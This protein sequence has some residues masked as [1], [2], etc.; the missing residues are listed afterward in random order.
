MAINRV[1]VLKVL[2]R[3]SQR[4]REV[5]ELRCEGLIYKEIGNQLHIAEPTVKSTMSHIYIKL[6]L[7]GL[8]TTQRHQAL[9]EIICPVLKRDD[10]P[11]AAEEP[12]IIE[13]VPSEVEEMVTEDEY[14]LVPVKPIS[15]EYH[16]PQSSNLKRRPSI[17]GNLGWLITGIALTAVVLSILGDGGE[18]EA[19]VT[20]Q[21]IEHT[22]I[23]ER[24]ATVLV[25]L[26]PLPVKSTELTEEAGSIVVTS[27][28][29]PTDTPISISFNPPGYIFIDDFERGP[30]P[31]WEIKYGQLGMA[32][33]KYTVTESFQGYDKIE[34][35]AVLNENYWNNFRLTLNLAPFERGYNGCCYAALGLILR[36]SGDGHSI[37][38][39]IHPDDVGIEFGILNPTGKWEPYAGSFVEGRDLDF[40]LSTREH[41]IV[42]EAIGETYLVFI[43][44]IQITSATIPETN[45]GAIGLWFVPDSTADEVESYAPRIES[46]TIEALP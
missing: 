34:H 11:P 30:D 37:G 35:F 25:T 43:G 41:K 26:T 1:D 4:E 16:P 31:L 23:V 2:S 19:A 40:D 5:L 8:E 10:L 6:E 45:W 22:V 3:L 20:P 24:E 18:A 46:I 21:I 12:E 29:P 15:L 9:F 38:L 44:N 32:N 27:T 42:I 17:L 36:E 28:S 33:G 39:F 14:A 13:P 7:N